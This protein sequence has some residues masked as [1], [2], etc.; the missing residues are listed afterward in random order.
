METLPDAQSGSLPDDPLGAF[1]RE[2][3]IAV[4]GARSGPLSGLSF[5]AKDVFAIA[6]TRTG[7]GHPDWLRTHGPETATAPAVQRLLDAGASLAGKTHADELCYSLTGENFHYGTPRNPRDPARVPGGSSSGSAVAVAGGLVDFALG[8]D[9]GGSIRIPASYCGIYGMRPTHG[10]IPLDGVTPFAP[11]FDTVGWFAR[12][13][14]LMLRIGRVLLADDPPCRPVRNLLIAS[15]AFAFM[16]PEISDTLGS[17][18]ER[19]ETALGVSGRRVPLAHDGLESWAPTFRAI[20]AAEIW[21]SLGGWITRTRPNFGPGVRDRFAAAANIDRRE[22]EAAVAHRARISA[23][24]RSLLEP[25]T[26]LCLPTAPRAAPPKGLPADEIEVRMRNQGIN[27]LCAA[28]L[29]G[30][31]QLSMAMAEAAGLP[32][33]LS[34]MGARG[35]DIDLLHAAVAIEAH[36]GSPNHLRP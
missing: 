35:A 3:H 19:L 12:D 2:N 27:L 6:G 34:I 33:G 22:V 14:D 4:S 31:P 29:S 5:A 11:S 26:I 20:Q 36:I 9:C 21:D 8:T 32:V 17:A 23:H 24:V 25:G 18:V 30:A 13:A 28:G 1:C 7:N 10:R 15:D 16:S